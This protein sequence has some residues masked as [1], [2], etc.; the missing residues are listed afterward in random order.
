MIDRNRQITHTNWLTERKKDRLFIQIAHR[1]IDDRNIDEWRINRAT[2]RQK[3]FFFFFILFTDKV[4]T[5]LQ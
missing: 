4:K 5:T 3:L 1:E 2:D